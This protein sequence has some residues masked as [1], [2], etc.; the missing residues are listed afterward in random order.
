MLHPEIEQAADAYMT[1]TVTNGPE[2]APITGEY[3]K[4]AFLAVVV[5]RTGEERD[6]YKA[7]LEY[8]HTQ[9]SPDGT[10]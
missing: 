2:G 6:R 1:K 9:E 10:D 8:R 3:L 7:A 4:Q 5:K